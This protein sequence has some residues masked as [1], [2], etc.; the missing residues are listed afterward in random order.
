MVRRF[1]LV[2]PHLVCPKCHYGTLVVSRRPQQP[3]PGDNFLY[4]Y[5]RCTHC[6]YRPPAQVEHLIAIDQSKSRNS[7]A[8]S[9]PSES[10][11]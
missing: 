1:R 6:P 3:K 10:P 11:D 4:T 5:R 9:E 8:L 2:E 7:A